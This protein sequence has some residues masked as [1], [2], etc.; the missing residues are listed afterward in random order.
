M[1]IG[2][3]NQSSIKSGGTEDG[4]GIKEQ[5]Q[6]RLASGGPPDAHL[7]ATQWLRVGCPPQGGW[8]PETLWRVAGAMLV[9]IVV[10]SER[11]VVEVCLGEVRPSWKHSRWRRIR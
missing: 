11:D 1:A 2:V 7:C 4:Q 8:S 5:A 6:R 10:C 3:Q 9:G